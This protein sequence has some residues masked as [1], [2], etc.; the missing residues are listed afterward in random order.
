MKT[1][2][3]K[4]TMFIIVAIGNFLGMLDSSTVNLGLY[5]M[6]RAFDVSISQV[7]WVVIAYMLVL[8][9]FLPFFGKLGDIFPKN[10]MYA[11]G[12]LIFAAGAAL[13]TVAAEFWQLILFRCIEALGASIMIS[14]ASAV[15][16]SIFRNARR[17]KALGLN[18]CI[19]AIGGMSGP[20]LGGFLINSFDWRAIFVPCI[21]I[22]VIGA[23]YA[24]RMLPSHHESRENFKFDY[25]GFLYF[26]ISIFALLLAI[27]EGH[28]WG[29]TSL[30]ITVLGIL[31]A[32]FG[33]LF[34]IR[35]HKIKN[36]MINFEIFKIKTFTLGNLAVMTSYMAMFTNSIL[37]PFFLQEILKYNPL[38]TGLLVLPY[39]VTLSVTA[40]FSGNWAGKHGSRILTMA[41]PLVYIIALVI[42]TTF[43]ETTPAWEI[44]AASGIMGIGN[45]LFQSPSNTAIIT[46]VKKSELGIASGILALSRNMGNILGVA[47]TISIFDSLRGGYLKSG[48]EYT[49]AFLN[50]YHNTMMVGILFGI[51]CF[52][53]AFHAY[54][55]NKI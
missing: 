16:A 12:F 44:I 55:N 21:P 15:I 25:P 51:T 3:L 52:T 53:L 36:P 28:Q 50:A 18:G 49:T 10:K 38:V 1:K 35:D 26:T 5:E 14:N 6:S 9:V 39:S 23:I 19:I 30:K 48:L 32:V 47:L 29:W 33:A 11:S 34:Y 31:T 37:L 7:Q 4:W 20:A 40:P 46:S 13:N 43:N 8:T 2:S 41:G 22:A 24:Y 54:R 27:S 45:G 17:G 42:F